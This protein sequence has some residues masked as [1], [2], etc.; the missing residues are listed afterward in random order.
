MRINPDIELQLTD[1]FINFCELNR[2]KLAGMKDNSTRMNYMWEKLPH[3]PQYLILR[4]VRPYLVKGGLG[5][6]YII[7]HDLRRIL[8]ENAHI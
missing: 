4:A 5:Y 7:L 1:E 6:L 2:D 3:V 8:P